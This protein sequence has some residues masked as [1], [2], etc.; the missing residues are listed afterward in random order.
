MKEIKAYVKITALEEV[1]SA[2]K[3]AGFCCMS[4]IDIS[5]L[6]NLIDPEQWKYSMEFV[7]KMSKVAKL[8]LACKDEDANEVVEII[9]K[10]GCTHQPGDG[11]IFVYT[12]ERAVKI[13]TGEEGENILQT[14]SAVK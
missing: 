3:H 6:G 5:G 8:E 2:L 10:H 11:I 7:Q 9:K 4:I 1:V 12:V 13:R 14:E